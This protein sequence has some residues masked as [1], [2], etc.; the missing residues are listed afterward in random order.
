MYHTYS[1]LLKPDQVCS[2]F[3]HSL[4]YVGLKFCD[5][6]HAYHVTYAGVSTQST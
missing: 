4:K 3:S 1:I 5:I 6:L 2:F